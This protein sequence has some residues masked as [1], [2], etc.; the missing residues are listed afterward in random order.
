MLANKH[1]GAVRRSIA[2]F[3]RGPADTN[4]VQLSF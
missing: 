3:L 4:G 2:Q 1:L